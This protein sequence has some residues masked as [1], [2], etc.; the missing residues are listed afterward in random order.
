MCTPY[1]TSTRHHS[2]RA[3]VKRPCDKSGIPRGRMA[4]SREPSSL[5]QPLKCH[6]ATVLD[7]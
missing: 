1:S 6:F 3:K 5:I 4:V 7:S 2:L